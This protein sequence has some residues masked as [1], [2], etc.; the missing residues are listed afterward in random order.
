MKMRKYYETRAFQFLSLLKNWK[1]LCEPLNTY[2]PEEVRKSA[3]RICFEQLRLI[4]KNGFSSNV[5]H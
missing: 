4:W 1:K 3:L 2:Y 5:Q